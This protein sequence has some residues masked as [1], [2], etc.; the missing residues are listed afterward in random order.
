MQVYFKFTLCV[1]AA[2][3]DAANATVADNLRDAEKKRANA[4]AAKAAK[5]KE[6]REAK[7]AA[8]TR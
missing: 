3:V 1:S 4:D 8:R 7:E 6:T 5:D 2:D